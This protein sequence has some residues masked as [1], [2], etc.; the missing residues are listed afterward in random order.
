M[1]NPPAQ[2]SSVAESPKRVRAALAFFPA[3]ISVVRSER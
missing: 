3:Q 2:I 1:I